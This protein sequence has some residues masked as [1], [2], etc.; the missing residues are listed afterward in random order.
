MNKLRVLEKIE[1]RIEEDLEQ[2]VNRRGDKYKK[3]KKGV[4]ITK[5][6]LLDS[7][8]CD[9]LEEIYTVILRDKNISIFDQPLHGQKGYFKLDDFIN[10]E[11]IYASHNLIKDLFGIS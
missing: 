8:N 5:Q 6:M 11:C 2:F 3:E 7:S 10:L 1:Q 9:T 4:H